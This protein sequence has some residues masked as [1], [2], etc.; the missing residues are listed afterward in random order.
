MA[1]ASMTM[2]ASALHIH[3]IRHT[4]E[5]SLT[6]VIGLRSARRVRCGRRAGASAGALCLTHRRSIAG[7]DIKTLSSYS[8]RQTVAA[9]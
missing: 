4:G 1:G 2:M 5:R 8:L 7:N 3:G 9:F 6:C